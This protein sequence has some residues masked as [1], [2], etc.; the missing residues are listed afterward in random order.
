MMISVKKWRQKILN[1]NANVCAAGEKSAVGGMKPPRAESACTITAG[2]DRPAIVTAFAKYKRGGSSEDTGAARAS[3]SA[4]TTQ[5]SSMVDRQNEKAG[6]RKRCA[7]GK[8]SN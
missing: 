5:I 6:R 1:G 7:C 2:G 4:K 3:K 8:R